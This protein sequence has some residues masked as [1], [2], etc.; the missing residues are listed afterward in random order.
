MDSRPDARRRS[1]RL[2]QHP[3]RPLPHRRVYEQDDWFQVEE[4]VQRFKPLF[5][6]EYAGAL[7]GE[8]LGYV[9]LPTQRGS[10]YVMAKWNDGRSHIFSDIPYSVLVGDP[11][12]STAGPIRG[13]STSLPA[14]KGL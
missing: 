12:T 3:Q 6:D 8:M 4:R 13:G 14:K 1:A 11:Y 2:L 9:S 7:L 5:N 10:E